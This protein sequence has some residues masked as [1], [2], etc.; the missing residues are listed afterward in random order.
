MSH[1][2]V[3]PKCPHCSKA[4]FKT[5]IKGRAVLK[6]D[7]WAYCRNQ[8]CVSYAKKQCT[9]RTADERLN[10]T[11]SGPAFI[12]APRIAAIRIPVRDVGQGLAPAVG[13]AIAMAR[14]NKAA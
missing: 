14:H 12:L 11:E 6:S 9:E 4:M 10:G 13:L 3:H 8:S 1:H 2:P 5:A 7:P